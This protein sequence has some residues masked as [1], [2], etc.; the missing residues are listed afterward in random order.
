MS[1]TQ[2]IVSPISDYYAGRS[3][4]ITGGTGFMGKVLLEKLLRSC[5]GINKIYVLIRTKK[6]QLPQDRLQA[7]LKGRLFL[8][9][10]SRLQA[11]Q[12]STVLSK[13]VAVAGD[14]TE[15]NLGISMAD[16]QMLVNDVS[17][18]FHAAATVKFD[19]DLADSIKMNVKG[20]LSI[21]NLARKVHSLSSFVHVSTAY[22]HCYTSSEIEEKFYPMPS[23]N[24]S[25]YSPDELIELCNEAKTNGRD[26]TKDII[27]VFPNTYTFTKAMAEKVIEEKASDLPVAIMRPS[28]VVASWKE[29]MP[30]WVDNLN[31]PTGM[32]VASGYGLLHSVLANRDK[33]AD[34]LPVDLAINLMC[35]LPWKLSIASMDSREN[36]NAFIYNCTSGSKAPFKWGQLED[37]HRLLL[38]YPVENMI[39]LPTGCP[40]KSNILHDRVCKL[41]YHWIPAYS[42]DG[43]MY[44]FNLQSFNLVKYVTK[45]TTAM[46]AL[47]FFS[48]REWTWEMN[49]STMLY[50][51]LSKADKELFGYSFRQFKW[52]EYFESYM[53]GIREFALK[54]K[55]ETMEESRSTVKKLYS[56]KQKV[57][58]SC[59]AV[60]LLCTMSLLHWYGMSSLVANYF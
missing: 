29:P 33:K 2:D 19:D 51:E 15:P 30:G 45:M 41:L 22:S 58:K 36:F 7:M 20:T 35:V 37:V 23:N 59:S 39:W 40:M 56:L 11:C 46:E 52:N 21:V 26:I 60:A 27:G 9:L 8:P 18:I 50:K 48:M 32:V 38:K 47:E 55:P 3:I 12:A 4:F 25:R 28:I 42:I 17:V 6:G 43:I 57:K 16:E 44:I 13:V 5:P 34:L 53:T 24:Y 31:G 49:N 10:T 54:Q 1:T 14:I